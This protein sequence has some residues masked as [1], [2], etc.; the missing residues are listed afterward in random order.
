MKNNN[1]FLF[2]KKT[3]KKPPNTNGRN[4]GGKNDKATASYSTKRAEQWAIL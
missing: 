1:F 2:L 3:K 4:L